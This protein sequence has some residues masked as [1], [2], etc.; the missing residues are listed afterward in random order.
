MTEK[1]FDSL[2]FIRLLRV[3]I[4]PSV[5]SMLRGE[6]DSKQSDEI[7]ASLASLCNKKNYHCN[8]MTFVQITIQIDDNVV[9]KNN[10]E[11][12]WLF[13]QFFFVFLFKFFQ[14]LVKN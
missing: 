3:V 2:N 11:L 12:F 14:D 6:N 8:T 4:T 9:D 5:T 7:Q 13:S 10:L 1:Y